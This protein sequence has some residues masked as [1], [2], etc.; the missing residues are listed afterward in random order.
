MFERR[1]THE[2]DPKGSCSFQSRRKYRLSNN[3]SRVT[4]SKVECRA[5]S[6]RQKEIVK[7]NFHFV[8]K[9]FFTF[10][11]AN[12]MLMISKGEGRIPL[13]KSPKYGGPGKQSTPLFFFFS[14][15]S[16][17]FP[18]DDVKGGTTESIKCCIVKNRELCY[19]Y[20]I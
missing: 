19:S 16:F 2:I 6:S 18:R 12:Y 17:C 20:T 7:F 10:A 3:W 4:W 1:V 8:R 14:L 15:Y 11:I 13:I 5:E 9:R